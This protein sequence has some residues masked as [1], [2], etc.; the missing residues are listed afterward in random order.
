MK[1]LVPDHIRIERIRS[2]ILSDLVHYQKDPIVYGSML[3]D[4]FYHVI[5]SIG[6]IN[7]GYSTKEAL[8]GK[9]VDGITKDHLNAPRRMCDVL[10]WKPEL[11][12][13]VDKFNTVVKYARFTIGVSEEQNNVVKQSMDGTIKDLS[14]NLYKNL[15]TLWWED[16]KGYNKEFPEQLIYPLLTEYETTLI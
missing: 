16:S 10:L 3:R 4:D 8:R 7:T 6:P 1:S 14:I 13:D 15:T 9:K 12:Y 5:N 11:L 2:H